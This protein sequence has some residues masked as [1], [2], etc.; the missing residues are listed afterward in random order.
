MTAAS[1]TRKASFPSS[2]V[3]LVE[4]TSCYQ[5]LNGVRLHF[6]WFC[7]CCCEEDDDDDDD[8][9]DDADDDG[10]EDEDDGDE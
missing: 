9:D 3:L 1:G 2:A 10:D 5:L 7:V 8:D 4:V 6:W